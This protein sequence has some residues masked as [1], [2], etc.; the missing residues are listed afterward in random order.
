LLRKSFKKT[1]SAI[2]FLLLLIPTIASITS[3][4]LKIPFYD[5][6]GGFQYK[7]AGA[8]ANCTKALALTDSFLPGSGEWCLRRPLFPELLSILYRIENSLTFVNIVLSILFGIAL[9]CLFLEVRKYLTFFWSLTLSLITLCYWFVYCCNQILTESLAI[10]FCTLSLVALLRARRLSDLKYAYL[11]IALISIAQQI[12][13][14]NL[15]LPL[16]P[17]V[18]LFMA[19][20]RNKIARLLIGFA[21]FFSPYLFTLSIGAK[22][23]ISNYANS[24]NA[25]A[26]LYGLANNNSTWQAAY[27]VPGIPAGATDAQTSEI[28]QSATLDLIKTKPLAVPTSVLENMIEMITTY[29]PFILPVTVP[30]SFIAVILNV[31][32]AIFTIFRVRNRLVLGSLSKEDFFLA[33]YILISTSVSYAIAWKSEPSRALMPSIAFTIFM[34]LFLLFGKQCNPANFHPVLQPSHLRQFTSQ[35]RETIPAIAVASLLFLTSYLSHNP[36]TEMKEFD[37][38]QCP[39]GSFKF[40]ENSVSVTSVDE[41]R[42]FPLFSWSADLPKLT[43][44]DLVQG[45]GISDEGVINVNT[46]L[47]TKLADA[48]LL[49]KCFILSSDAPYLGGFSDSG[50]KSIAPLN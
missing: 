39:Q 44:G 6:A 49:L 29:F 50:V 3:A 26:S 34:F 12:R 9:C 32:L 17:I 15:F 31:S 18:L 20:N 11:S 1:P 42:P 36:F 16:A 43:S 4:A 28:I 8:W 35:V 46:F 10:T 5:S 47:Q 22:L 38:V 30:Y 40:L 25:W 37:A 13:P 48:D 27:S 45:L 7:D 23:G 33:T 14:G 21:L 41:I 2:A 19:S 24:G